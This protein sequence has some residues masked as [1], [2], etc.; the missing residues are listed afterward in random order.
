MPTATEWCLL[1]LLPAATVRKAIDVLLLLSKSVS[2]FTL[3]HFRDTVGPA[4]TLALI[5]V[6]LSRAHPLLRDDIAM[7][8]YEMT[9]GADPDA[10]IAQPILVHITGLSDAQRGELMQSFPQDRDGPNFV[11]GLKGFLND[12]EFLRL[13]NEAAAAS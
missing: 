5:D 13:C 2:L 1:L 7:L 11:R 10:A 4:F 6:L 3:Q 12:V 8:L 9:V